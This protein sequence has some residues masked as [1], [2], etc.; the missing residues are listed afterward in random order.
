MTTVIV[1]KSTPPGFVFAYSTPISNIL[2]PLWQVQKEGADPAA[3]DDLRQAGREAYNS[4]T[5]SR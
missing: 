4:S 5:A 1:F 3:G 2:L